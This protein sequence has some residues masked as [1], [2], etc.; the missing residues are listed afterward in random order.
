MI[1]NYGI[2]PHTESSL[3]AE[4]ITLHALANWWDVAA[5]A[6]KLGRFEPGQYEK[7][8]SFLEDPENWS[9]RRATAAR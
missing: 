1:F 5:M 9:G 8:R 7:V 2:F 3:A 4:G 6:D